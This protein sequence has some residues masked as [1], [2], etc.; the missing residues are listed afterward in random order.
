VLSSQFWNNNEEENELKDNNNKINSLKKENE[1]LANQIIRLSK[2][3]PDE[4]NELQKQYKNLD[5]KYKQLL[6]AN[7]KNFSYNNNISTVKIPKIPKKIIIKSDNNLNVASNNNNNNLNSNSTELL[8]INSN[9]KNKY[10]EQLN[11]IKLRTEKLIK[12]LLNQM[13]IK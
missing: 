1:K 10:N 3:I 5:I 6:L 4:Y 9:I 12:N 7:N 11:N 13:N 2:N 8:K